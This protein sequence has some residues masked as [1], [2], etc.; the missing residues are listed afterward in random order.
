MKAIFM[1]SS[2]PSA[3]R[4]LVSDGSFGKFYLLSPPSGSTILENARIFS[5]IMNVY[6]KIKIASAGEK[7]FFYQKQQNRATKFRL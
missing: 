2:V 4:R 6:S 5:G 1:C 3:L 7:K